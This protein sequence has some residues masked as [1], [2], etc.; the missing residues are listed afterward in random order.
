MS[1]VFGIVFSNVIVIVFIKKLTLVIASVVGS[2]F[3]SVV[4][5]FN[6]WDVF[7]CYLFWKNICWLC[8]EYNL[9]LC[10][11]AM[12]GHWNHTVCSVSGDLATQLH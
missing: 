6:I 11:L 5:N 1:I 12:E 2:V 3:G 10:T 9:C 7:V 4:M 8:R